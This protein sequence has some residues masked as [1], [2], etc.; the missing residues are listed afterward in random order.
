MFRRRI[1]VRDAAANGSAIPDRHV[2][3]LRGRLREQRPSL[4]HIG[5]AQQIGVPDQRPD[6]QAI[7]SGVQA[8]EGVDAIDIDDDG[9]TEDAQV[10]HRHQ[11]LAAGQ[12]PAVRPGVAQ[13]MQGL[14]ERPR[15]VVVE[16]GRLHVLLNLISK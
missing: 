7:R 13:N 16:P 8:I 6:C 4:A 12:H 2:R 1:V 9:G 10:Q 3:D 11:A 15:G 5:A 14:V